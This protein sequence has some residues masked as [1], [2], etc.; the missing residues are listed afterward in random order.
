MRL[1]ESEIR[2]CGFTK[3]RFW[4]SNAEIGQLK[5]KA[6]PL[7]IINTIGEDYFHLYVEEYDEYLEGFVDKDVS[8]YKCKGK[9]GKH[10]WVCSIN[11]SDFFEIKKTEDILDISPIIKYDKRLGFIYVIYSPK[12]K[13]KIGSSKSIHSR[14]KIFNVKLSVK[15]DFH[16][17]YMSNKYKKLEKALHQL[18]DGKRIEGEWFDLNQKDL[19]TIEKF[20][21]LNAP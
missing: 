3:L 2:R 11:D 1:N 21:E 8:I 15:W 19:K 18:F 10:L 17:I 5:K 7:K 4:N 20:I 16:N 9:R 6:S 14:T 12:L 13:F